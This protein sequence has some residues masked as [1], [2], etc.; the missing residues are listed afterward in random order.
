MSVGPWGLESGHIAV[1]TQLES[2][3][4]PLPSAIDSQEFS[5]KRY[6]QSNKHNYLVSKHWTSL[7]SIADVNLSE[8][9]PGLITY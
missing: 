1:G 4:I 6:T 7:G 9:S 3:V 2:T 8:P 5:I